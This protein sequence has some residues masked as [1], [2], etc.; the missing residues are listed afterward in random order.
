MELPERWAIW[1]Y[2]AN[3]IATL[4]VLVFALLS[5]TVSPSSE[6]ASDL[7][8]PLVCGLAALSS[9]GMAARVP[10]RAERAAWGLFAASY[11]LIFLADVE[12]LLYFLDGATPPTP[13]LADVLYLGS[14]APMLLGLLALPAGAVAP[15]VRV[16]MGLDLATVF[17]GAAMVIGLTVIV[18]VAG[19]DTDLTAQVIAAGSPVADVVLLAAIALL[20]LRGVV[21]SLRTTLLLLLISIGITV[22]ADLAYARASLEGTYEAGD[23]MNAWWM[24]GNT[25][26]VWAANRPA[27]PRSDVSAIRGVWEW[28]ADALPYVG[29]LAGF[30]TLVF[31]ASGAIEPRPSLTV[32]AVLLC[33]L[34]AA[35]QGHLA[36]QNRAL[37]G[38][39]AVQYDKSE[40]LLRNVLPAS[41][42][43]R[44][45]D[46]PTE[47][48]ADQID[49]ATVLFADIVGFT[50]LSAKTPPDQ[51][52]ALLDDVFSRFD[53][54]ADRYGIEK[55]KTIG[56]AYMAAS[57][58]P[59]PDA[60][61]AANAARAAL[62]MI[63]AID[64]LNRERG[65]A[66]GLRVGLNTGPVVAGIIGTKRFSYDLWG[67]VVNTASRMESH[68]VPHAIHLTATTH[69]H[70]VGRFTLTSRGT[71]EVKGK[72]PMETWLLTPEASP[73]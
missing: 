32:G 68:G 8:A 24:F 6:V 70:L 62:A 29:M 26:F 2:A 17:I 35:R 12:W 67:D 73:E 56:D 25:V 16:R 52:L 45:L 69:R 64:D 41:I 46:R 10:S 60:D 28:A 54:I 39:L 40:R 72:G 9:V 65:L 34:V 55:I 13:S 38:E 7:I 30:A 59:K 15:A 20:L 3:G 44:L 21:P 47:P 19:Q 23:P 14:Y 50:P 1:R 27:A 5:A 33:G 53:T 66:L 51:L 63:Q 57:G 4:G 37:H 22:G 18:P 31:L 11:A 58:V 49:E 36:L 42:A 48:I 71:L 43:T 61:H